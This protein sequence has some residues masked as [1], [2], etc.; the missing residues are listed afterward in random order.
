[1]ALFQL[2]MNLLLNTRQFC[3]FRCCPSF[4]F[5][6]NLF[7]YFPFFNLFGAQQICNIVR[8]RWII[9][10]TYA[11]QVHVSRMYEHVHILFTLFLLFCKLRDVFNQIIVFSMYTSYVFDDFFFHFLSA[12]RLISFCFF[13]CSF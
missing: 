4:I 6:F 9:T 11:F 1:M 12:A 5:I 2:K 3:E 7:F 13:C 10:N 8:F